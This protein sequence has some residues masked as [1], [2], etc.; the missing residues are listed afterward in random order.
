MGNNLGGGNKAKVM[1]INGETF[2]LKTPA[3]AG[4]VVKDYPGYVLLDSEAVKHFGIRAKPLEPQQEL[5]A[6][7]IYFLIELPQIPE[8]KDPRS[9]R[10][11]RSAIQMS[12]KERLEN[13]MLSRRSVSDLSMVRPSSSQT[14][15]GREPVQVKVRLPKAQVQKLVEESQD[16]VEVAEKLI[17]LYM[18]NSGGIN[19]TDGHRHVHWKPELGIITESFKAAN[20]TNV[21]KRVSFAQ[22]EGETR[23][24]V[25]S[26]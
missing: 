17:D 5:K 13:L 6:K 19:G 25:A 2:K 10:R 26:A 15:D 12:A 18:R 22:E 1:L 3:T 20:E 21:Q 11:V 24:A 23:L 7:K 8:E 14:S 16:E 9:T 4:E